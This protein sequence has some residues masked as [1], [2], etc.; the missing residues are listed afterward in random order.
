M[1]RATILVFCLAAVG[2]CTSKTQGLNPADAAPS[3]DTPDGMPMPGTDDGGGDAL[4]A[5]DVA[6]GVQRTD[7]TPVGAG[8]VRQTDGATDTGPAQSGARGF[9]ATSPWLAFYDTAEALGDLTAIANKFRII[10]I[11]VDPGLGNYTKEQVTT[12][13]GNGRN[14]VLSYFNLGACE[15]FRVYWNTVPSGFL[16]CSANKAAQLGAYEGWPNEMWMNLGN[17]D[18][19]HL[20]VDHMA[21]NLASLGIDGFY[22]DNLDIVDHGTNTSN[23]PCDAAC[24]QGALDVVRMLRE[25]YPDMLFVMQN[26]VGE[27]TL[28]GVTG[29]VAFPQL[30]DGVVGENTFT[31]LPNG[32]RSLL[33]DLLLW[34][35]LD[36]KPGGHPFW[37]GTVEYLPSCSDT[38]IAKVVQSGAS[39]GFTTYVGLDSDGLSSVCPYWLK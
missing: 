31:P 10:N 35:A 32:D 12:L 37:I 22:L 11:D 29:G 4:P 13:K 5:A 6:D 14:R 19:Q 1:T 23:G 34:Q 24:V 15:D 21:P 36:L 33:A 9:P 27:N 17:A 30:L 8:D 25:K 16:S 38:N 3:T 7:G 28:E 2:A 26:A 20:V 18:Y 39:Q